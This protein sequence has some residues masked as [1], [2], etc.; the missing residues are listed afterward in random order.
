MINERG[1]ST[2]TLDYCGWKINVKIISVDNIKYILNV[3]YHGSKILGLPLTLHKDFRPTCLILPIGEKIAH[4]TINTH[5]KFLG[6]NKN[7]IHTKNLAWFEINVTDINLLLWEIAHAT[8]NYN[9]P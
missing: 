6:K 7:A 9:G 8:E 2:T 1:V 3:E 5:D 4:N